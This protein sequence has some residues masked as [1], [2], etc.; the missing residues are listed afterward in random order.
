MKE[1]GMNRSI[2]DFGMGNSWLMYIKDFGVNIIKIDMSLV[3]EITTNVQSQEIVRYIISLSSQLNIEVVAEGV[4]TA[5]QR[6][7]LYEL[8]CKLYQG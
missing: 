8:G 2:D 5:E 6:D 3:R 7:K 4:E 1:K